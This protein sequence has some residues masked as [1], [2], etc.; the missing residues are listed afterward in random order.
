MKRIIIRKLR[1]E[2]AKFKLEKELQEAFMEGETL[3]EV[4]HGIGEGKLKQLTLD[5]INTYDYL[6]ELNKEEWMNTNPGVTK[7][8]ILGITKKE[9]KRYKR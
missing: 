4:L 3:V 7:I 9:I 5:T 8:E 1:Y 6:K 2:E